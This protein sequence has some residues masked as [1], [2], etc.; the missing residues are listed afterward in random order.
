V[1]LVSNAGCSQ[2]WAPDAG[3]ISKVESSIKP[4]DIP[5]RYSPGHPPV[6][7]QYAR[8]YF[9]YMA[10]NHRM[11]RGELVLPFGSKMKPAGIYVVD[12]QREFPTIFDGGCS[13][14]HVVYDVD[15]GRLVS[16]QCNGVA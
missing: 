12:S 10:N 7:G 13:V 3:I 15:A 1:L 2:S 5:L 6:I 8:Y 14:M 4:S 11:I 16:L 9:G